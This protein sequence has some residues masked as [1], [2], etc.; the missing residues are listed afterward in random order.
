MTSE[1]SLSSTHTRPPAAGGTVPGA[2]RAPSAGEAPRVVRPR[3]LPDVLVGL[4]AVAAALVVFSWRL[5]TPSPWRDE[6]VTIAVANRSAEDVWRLV[7]HVDLVHAPFYFLVHAL[8][9][10]SADVGD[11]R[12]ISV[13]AAALTAPLL[14]GLGR[15]LAAPAVGPGTARLTGATAAALFVAMP[16]V[17]RYAQEARPYA[18]ATLL[19]TASTYLLVRA[20]T[21]HRRVPWAAYA[22]T[23]PLLVAFNTVAALVLVAHAG[24]LLTA[25]ARVLRRGAAAAAAGLAA[26]LPLVLAQSRQS[27]QVAFLQR[28]ALAELGSH[29]L[30]ALGSSVVALVVAALAVALALWRARARRLLLVGL[31][32]GVLPWPLLWALS[33]LK[34]FWTTRYLVFVAP[35]TCLLLAAVV[36]L[37]LT[38]RHR[39]AVAGATAAL[40]VAGLAVTGL[41]MQFVFRDPQIGHA[42]DLR[43]TARY[44]AEHARPG[45]GLLFVPDGEYRYRVLTQLYPQ[46]F[47]ALDDI[48]LAE[49]A[50][51]S[52]TLVGQTLPADRLAQAVQGVRRIWVVGGTGRVVT[53]TAADRET[54]RLLD[55]GYQLVSTEERRAFSVRLYVAR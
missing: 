51:A 3:R 23:L 13:V 42:E 31:L 17:S 48:A 44:V 15:R 2:R 45:D 41:H 50:A 53:A 49:P 10:G 20:G 38:R 19:A 14:F 16:F 21:G 9:G 6:A 4:A 27:E 18:I 47:A 8:F 1:V 11:A 22:L 24:W 5:S 32:W 34:P 37:A 35:G 26:A 36:T 28:P 25:P 30:F 52:A 7:Q 46:A 40:L 55:A 12:W 29:V 39:A 54:V 33:Q 43:G